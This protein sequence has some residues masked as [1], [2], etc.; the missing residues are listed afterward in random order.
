MWLITF[1]DN[2]NI[3]FNEML[4]Y[5]NVWSSLFCIH[6]NVNINFM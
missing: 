5:G 1:I 2:I 6:V 4:S 3:N